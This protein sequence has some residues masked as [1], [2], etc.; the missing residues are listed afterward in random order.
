M[1]IVIGPTLPRYIHNMIINFP[2]TF[3]PGVTSRDNPTVAIALVTSKTPSDRESGFVARSRTENKINVVAGI[4]N[5]E[6]NIAMDP[7]TPLKADEP[8][9]IIMKKSDLKRFE[10]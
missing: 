1:N 9:L 8:L 4:Q 7:D 6:F 3:S 2:I 5:D 10:R